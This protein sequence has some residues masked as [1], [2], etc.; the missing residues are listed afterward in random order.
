MCVC[1]WMFTFT[2][3]SLPFFY[4][5]SPGPGTYKL[6]ETSVTKQRMP[7]YSINGRHRLTTDTV[8]SPG[9]GAYSP[10][11]VRHS[12]SACI[13]TPAAAHLLVY[14]Y[15][16]THTHTHTHTCPYL[17]V[18]YYSLLP[19]SP[20]VVITKTLPPSFSFGVRHSQYLSTILE[21]CH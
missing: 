5:Q 18:Y 11:K 13:H 20:Q 14:S 17:M 21:P 1:V 8:N 2:S 16:H 6:V 10:E 19:F 7:S 9:P 4:S 3:S 12:T 15:I